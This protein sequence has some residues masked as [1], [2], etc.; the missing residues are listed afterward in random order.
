MTTLADAKLTALEAQLATTGHVNDLELLWLQALGATSGSIVDAWW[1]VFDAAAIPPGQFNDR[2]VAYIVSVAGAPLSDDY[3]E[4]WRHYWLNATLGPAPP[5][6]F[7]NVQHW[8]DYTDPAVTFS[9]QAGTIPSVLGGAIRHIVNKGIDGTPA[10]TTD[11]DVTT[12]TLLEMGVGALTIGRSIDALE[13]LQLTHVLP[14]GATGAAFA[15]VVRANQAMVA[16]RTIFTWGGMGANMVQNAGGPSPAPWNMSIS[17][18]GFIVSAK[19]VVADEWVSILVSKDGGTQDYFSR[20]SGTPELNSSPSPYTPVPSPGP[21]M[22]IFSTGNDDVELGELIIWDRALTLSER[23]AVVAYFDAKYGALPFLGLPSTVAELIHHYDFPDNTTVFKNPPATQLASDG[24][25]IRVLHDK[26]SRATDLSSA[27]DVNSP[28]YR[29]GILNSQ[30]IADFVPGANSKRLDA[31]EAVGQLGSKGMTNAIVFKLPGA[32]GAAVQM[33]DW[34]SGGARLRILRDFG[35]GFMLYDYPGPVGAFSNFVIVPDA[36]YLWY[37]SFTG[38]AVPGDDRARLSGEVQQI[39]GGVAPDTIPP[40]EAI[41]FEH[42]LGQDIQIAEWAVWDGPLTDPELADLEAYVLQKYGVLPLLPPPVPPFLANLT[43]WW[44]FT[45]AGSVFADTLGVVPITD[46]TIIQRVNDKGLA[47]DD[48]LDAGSAITWHTGVVNGLPVARNTVV[49]VPSR[50]T[51]QALTTLIGGVGGFT[52]GG[53]HR[54]FNVP[55]GQGILHA[56]DNGP[57]EVTIETGFGSWSEDHPNQGTTPSNKAVVGNEWV[58]A[59]V[60]DGGPGGY[61]HH[62]SAAVD[63][64]AIAAFAIQTGTPVEIFAQSVDGEIGEILVYDRGLTAAELLTLQ[65]YY[66]AKYATL[67]HL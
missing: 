43:H 5:P 39:L 17:G 20:V 4:H 40:G 38:A 2:A 3:N 16:A 36:W 10:T 54:L 46:G 18:G 67:P 30:N 56:I 34:G 45:D 33:V 13:A 60:S 62:V 27:S 26:G 59:I 48:L 23:D 42:V 52:Y 51:S 37:A 31:V 58:S 6:A 53:V 28:I 50:F 66:D 25:F 19:P 21:G 49:Q 12:V 24:D 9:N 44:D 32:L 63:V 1:E 61:I 55:G 41:A 11:G 14:G 15:L 35:A 7:A 22:G 29:T 47:A 8:F 64:T 57:S 65:A